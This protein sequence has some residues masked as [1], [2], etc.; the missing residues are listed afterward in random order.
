M[1]NTQIIDQQEILC[2]IDAQELSRSTQT[3]DL[4]DTQ[5]IDQNELLRYR[6]NFQLE[7]EIGAG[8]QGRV[9]KAYHPKTGNLYALKKVDITC[10]CTVEEAM[11]LNEFRHEH[12][13]HLVKF[14]I[15]EDRSVVLLL[16]LCDCDLYTF[17]Q[18]HDMTRFAPV[19][20]RQILA[21][22]AYL[23]SYGL[24]HRDI[25]SHNIM[26]GSVGNMIKISDFGSARLMAEYPG[27]DDSPYT[28]VP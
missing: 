8:A 7:R 27:G 12:V 2:S 25:K 16:E 21:A 15:I 9:Y 22:V 20:A 3:I 23:H 28:S 11:L 1:S 6:I 14:W 10:P 18:N 4:C 13:V 24:M 19:F 26:I 5:T 17:I